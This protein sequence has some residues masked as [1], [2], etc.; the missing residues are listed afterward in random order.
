VTLSELRKTHPDKFNMSQD[1]FNGELF[2]ERELPPYHPAPDAVVIGFTAD[3]ATSLSYAGSL[4]LAYVANPS[5]AAWKRYLWTADVD[6]F[7]QRVYVGDNGKGFELH[8]HIHITER[9]GIPIYDR[10]HA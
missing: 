1:W 6:S 4:A 2:M 9:F 10:A 3:A 7:G 8:R 5:A